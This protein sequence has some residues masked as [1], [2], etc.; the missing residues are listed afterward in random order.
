MRFSR[1]LDHDIKLCHHGSSVNVVVWFVYLRRVEYL[2]G[3][4]VNIIMYTC[5]FIPG[6]H[7]M[8]LCIV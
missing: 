6:T 1:P 2:I 7:G 4:L 8:L 3:Y 5:S